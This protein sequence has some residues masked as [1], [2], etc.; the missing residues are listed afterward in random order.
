MC[1]STS[2]L[3]VKESSLKRAHLQRSVRKRFIPTAKRRKVLGKFLLPQQSQRS[4][5]PLCFRYSSEALAKMPPNPSIEG[6]PKTLRVSCT[7]HV[8]R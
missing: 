3:R 6:M 1:M 7:P 5:L 8:K 4:G 2:A